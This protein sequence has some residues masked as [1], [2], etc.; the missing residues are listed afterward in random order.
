[1]LPLVTF[2]AFDLET[3]GLHPNKDEIIEVAGYKFT[4]RKDKGRL[5]AIDLG[6]YSSLIKPNM[7]IPKEAT[8]INN[9]TDQM[10]ENAPAFKKVIPEFIKFCGISTV[11]VAHK[12]DFDLEFL[13]K[14]LKKHQMMIPGNP[15]LDS[16][17]ITKKIMVEA[18][19]HNLGNL[20]RKLGD[21]IH[22]TLNRQGLHRALYDCEVLKEIFCAC[23]RK[24]FQEKEL[25]MD[26]A[27]S[28]IEKIHGPALHVKN[29]I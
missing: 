23:L 11:M 20:A 16:L 8:K 10:V 15:V 2:V 4:L 19:S 24:R 9:I 21:Q 28:S 7:F 6:H 3:T 1:M 17:K 26:K 27:I 18:T 29:F 14:A 5:T 22:L 13:G 12:A 25:T